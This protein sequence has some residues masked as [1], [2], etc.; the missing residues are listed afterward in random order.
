MKPGEVLLTHQVHIGSNEIKLNQVYPI[1][2]IQRPDWTDCNYFVDEIP[3]RINDD[4]V[5]YANRICFHSVVETSVDLVLGKGYY[6]QKD[7]EWNVRFGQKQGW[8]GGDGIYS[9]NLTTGKDQFDMKRQFTSLF[10][11]GDT[12]YGRTDKTTKRRYE[13]LLMPNNSMGILEASSNR[14]EFLVN[15]TEKDSVTAFFTI[16]PAHDV[17]GT[18]PQNLVRYDQAKEDEG[19]LSGN[20]PKKVWL[21]FDLQTVQEVDTIRIQNYYSQEDPSLSSRG[22]RIFR[23]LASCDQKVW[24]DLGEYELRKSISKNDV[25]AISVSGAFR[26]FQFDIHSGIG[27]GNHGDEYNEGVFA[28]SKVEFVRDGVKYRDIAVDASSVMLTESAKSWIWLQDGCVIGKQLYFFPYQVISDMSQPEGLQ[29]GIL[30]ISMIRVPIVDNRIDSKRAIQKRTP[31]LLRQGGSE[32]AFGG[33]VTANTVQAGAP[34][35]DGYVY[36]YGYKT[37]W[38]FR[39]LIAARVLEADFESFDR[40]EFY[41]GSMWTRDIL[42]C[43]PILDHLSTEFSISPILKGR[44]K[45]KYLAVFT[46]DTNTPYVAISL[47]ESLVGPFDQPQIV[48]KTPEQEIF[49]STTYTYNAKAHPQLSESDNILVT[50]N[51]NTYNFEHNMSNC[52]IYGPRFLR[53]KEW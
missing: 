50:Y 46:Y 13:P 34:N 7:E 39:Q 4:L 31:F 17:K 12:F 48:Y 36:V 1:Q 19:W 53:L 24:T 15:K 11:F 51:T 18:L 25:Q 42:Q 6:V 37:T 10:V 33:A 45:G 40:W 41:N 43:A 20:H 16:D 26:Y 30:G 14:I 44:H 21:L 35:P 9:F 29:F 2:S 47:G 28:L 22:V 32:L 5:V 8:S 3:S 27:I 52:D 49:K 23:L 38:G